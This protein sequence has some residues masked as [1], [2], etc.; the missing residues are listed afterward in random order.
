[1]SWKCISQIICVIILT[2]SVNSIS[3]S[4]GPAPSTGPQASGSIG[5][6]A[7]SSVG[8]QASGSSGPQASG[9]I[10]P[11]ASGSIG[12]QASGSIGSQASGSIGPQPS[13]TI[14]PQGSG[15]QPSGTIG[16]Q[17]SGPQPSGT[18]GPQGSGPQ[19]SGT[20]GPQGSGPQPSGTLGPQGNGSFGQLDNLGPGN[21][22][23]GPLNVSNPPPSPVNYIFGFNITSM[24]LPPVAIPGVLA[25]GQMSL[26]LSDSL[27][28]ATLTTWI[29]QCPNQPVQVECFLP[30]APPQQLSISLTGITVASSGLNASGAPSLSL[31]VVGSGNPVDCS[32]AQ[33]GPVDMIPLPVTITVSATFRS[34][35]GVTSFS[36]ELRGGGGIV[37]GNARMDV[38]ILPTLWPLFDD[39]IVVGSDGILR[40]TLLGSRNATGPLLSVSSSSLRKRSLG[41]LVGLLVS[42]MASGVRLCRFAA[43]LFG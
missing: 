36:C 37:L 22:S 28:Q 12:P 25:R 13:G 7:S 23:S 14:G 4:S 8:P 20:L 27:P 18:L 40:S 15:P 24:P 26:V 16:P 19:P 30:R 11:Q 43:I 10:G 1:M 38:N 2:Q 41:W 33:A 9:S 35:S 5:P 34:P 42:R 17:G 6:Q 29:N 32:S 39:V 31:V 3:S 21:G